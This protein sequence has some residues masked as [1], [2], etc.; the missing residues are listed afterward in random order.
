MIVHRT[1]AGFGCTRVSSRTFVASALRT[2]VQHLGSSDTKKLPAVV[3]S[4]PAPTFTPQGRPMQV[5]T[6]SQKIRGFSIL[7]PLCDKFPTL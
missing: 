2:D 4:V 5:R 7:T 1:D 3:I 6:A